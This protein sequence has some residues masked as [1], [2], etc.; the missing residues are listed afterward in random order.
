VRSPVL[1]HAAIAALLSAGVAATAQADRAADGAPSAPAACAA[2]DALP[3]A[4]TISETRAAVLCLINERRTSLEHSALQRDPALLSAAQHYARDLAPNRPLVH[5]DDDGD[6]P[7]KRLRA[8]RYDDHY[9]AFAYAETLGRSNG[10]TATPRERVAEWLGNPQTREVLLAPRFRDIGIGVEVSG[11]KVTFVV[12]VAY[13]LAKR[14]A[15]ESSKRSSGRSKRS[16]KSS[17]S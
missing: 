7:G 14:T 1:C 12:D 13:P 3:T 4:T 8:S 5:V 2:T 11:T 17:R 16:P 9:G 15:K 6:G 10:D